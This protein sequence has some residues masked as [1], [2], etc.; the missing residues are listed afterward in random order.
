MDAGPLGLASIRMVNQ[1]FLLIGVWTLFGISHSVL[2]GDRLVPLFGS[3]S[4]L[5][6]NVISVVMTAIPFGILYAYPAIPL[7]P[8]PSWL[9]WT[10][11]AVFSGVILSFIHTLKFYSV[12][13]FLGL[14]ADIW[15]LTFSPWHYWI[16]HP[17]YFLA[18]IFVWV[19][20]MTDTWLIS[21]ICITVY[22]VLGSRKEEARLL[23]IHPGSYAEYLSIVPGLI[24][25]RGRALDE[26]TRARLEATALKE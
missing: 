20:M 9:V 16:R 18:L 5:A 12:S 8:D 11:I 13:G 1:Y 15:P 10:R 21:A 22:I 23:A 4:R 26:K 3:R 19:Q 6:Y 14:K 24:P 17:W 2:A 7:W 25:W